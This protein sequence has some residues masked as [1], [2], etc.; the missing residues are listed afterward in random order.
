MKA[1]LFMSG[2][3]LAS[4]AAAQSAAPYSVVTLRGQ[5]QTLLAGSEDLMDICAGEILQVIYTDRRMDLSIWT[6]SPNGRFLVF[7]GPATEDNG[8]L[9]QQIDRVID[10]QDGSGNSNI[11]HI[12]TG[13]CVLSGNLAQAPVQ[14]TCEA[15]DADGATYKFAFL[16]DGSVPESMLD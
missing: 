9:I 11:E 12:A 4:P 13:Q 8:G 14:I 10:G 1:L 5:C 6:D 2:I 7:S 3:L 16:T 15:T